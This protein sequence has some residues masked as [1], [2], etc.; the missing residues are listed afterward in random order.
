MRLPRQPDGR[1]G[2]HPGRVRRQD[3]LHVVG[4]HLPLP[5]RRPPEADP[6]AHPV[7][8]QPARPDQLGQ[9]AAGD[10]QQRLQ[11]ERPVLSVAEAQPEPP[12][13]VGLG[14]DVRD[15]PLVAADRDRLAEAA[16]AQ[17][18]GDDRPPTA[19]GWR[20]AAGGGG[21]SARPAGDG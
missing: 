5:S 7:H 16:D 11:L 13:G 6:P 4:L 2:V 21:S 19:E 8:R 15:A 3:R 9:G 18:P 20:G 12:A 10:P 14:L 17:L 1:P